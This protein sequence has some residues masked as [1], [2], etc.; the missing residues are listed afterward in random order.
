MKTIVALT[1]F[2]PLSVN[3][4]NYAA[5]VAAFVH[6]DLQII[7]VCE[8]PIAFSEVPLPVY[9]IERMVKDAE[10]QLA[11]LKQH[12]LYRLPNQI[13]IE[14]VVKQGDILAEVNRY[15]EEVQP[16]AVMMGAETATAFEQLLFGGK[17]ITAV[18]QL[19]WPVMVVPEDVQFKGFKKIGLASDFKNVVDSIPAAE[20]KMMVHDFNAEL[21]VVNVYPEKAGDMFN[22]SNVAES[23]LLQTLLQDLNP[24]YHFVSDNDVE[25]GIND[26]ADKNQLDMLIIIPKKH[27]LINKIFRQSQSKRMVLHM[28]VPV[29]SIH[30]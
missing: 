23:G 24:T 16:Y 3:A 6:A 7:N 9:D 19:H 17:T 2:T 15:C 1:N 5:D 27:L 25:E 14:T 10:R 8:L 13:N 28:H 11:D 12:I 29:L 18:H 26:F 4:V 30:E 21:H 22:A 20:I